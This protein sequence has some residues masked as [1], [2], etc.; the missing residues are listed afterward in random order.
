MSAMMASHGGGVAPAAGMTPETRRVEP[1]AAH[2]VTAGLYE[3][4]AA[5][6]QLTRQWQAPEPFLPSPT[7]GN[8]DESRQS[9][10]RSPGTAGGP[11]DSK[12]P[13]STPRPTG[14]TAGDASDP[15]SARTPQ[16]ESASAAPAADA[17]G[18]SSAAPGGEGIALAEGATA[19][20][21][22][23]TGAW[24]RGEAW[25]GIDPQAAAREGAR[26]ASESTSEPMG[27]G[28]AGTVEPRAQGEGA[29][30]PLD[31]GGSEG[32]LRGAGGE[33]PMEGSSSW[34]S[35]FASALDVTTGE[36]T[37]SAGGSLAEAT[38]AGTGAP[39]L[40]S[41]ASS[42]WLGALQASLRSQAAQGLRLALA[43]GRREA[44]IDLTPPHLGRLRIRV[45]LQGNQVQAHVQAERPDVG[46]W[47][48]SDQ[49]WL[50]QRLAEQGLQLTELR[51]AVTGEETTSAEERPG[52]DAPRSDHDS[53]DGGGG[54]GRSAGAASA[55]G[56]SDL[57][58]APSETAD[59]TARAEQR[60]GI[61]LRV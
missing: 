17:G 40:P 3:L 38:L 30:T 18:Q 26:G 29:G 47:L 5:S 46:A 39:P 41:A 48:E 58:G 4:L 28:K 54:T 50:R 2:A 56:V 45:S 11:P 44:L 31:H 43:E 15:R 14:P 49:E 22:A 27:V 53:R 21:P 16:A 52:A 37:S 13:E 25:R 9:A 33:R 61:D 55:P 23:A 7:G 59:G 20:L 35:P 32:D 42:A 10:G 8:G 1:E 24:A 36:I 57:R 12:G 19:T 6:A 34:P 51:V 60:A